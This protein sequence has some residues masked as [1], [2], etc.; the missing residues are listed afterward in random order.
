MGNPRKHKLD[1]KLIER[2]AEL[3]L[4]DKEIAH[5]I[6]IPYSTF[7]AYIPKDDKLK[8]ALEKGKQSPNRRVEQ[9]L[10]RRAL[11]YNITEVT[12]EGGQITKRVLKHL[13]PDVRAIELWLRN[14]MP[15][16]WNTPQNLNLNLTLRD[17]VELARQLTN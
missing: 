11:G 5:A 10:Y 16:R 12:E 3:G 13:A 1:Y 17:K 6:D 7:E 4:T 14:R 2:L 8:K 9:A 15:D